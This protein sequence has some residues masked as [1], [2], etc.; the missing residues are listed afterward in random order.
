M[1]LKI[2]CSMQY[3]ST[4]KGVCGQIDKSAVCSNT[5]LFKNA[6]KGIK[7]FKKALKD[8]QN[9]LKSMVWCSFMW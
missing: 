6:L 9:A 3:C 8:L 7:D 5:A 4:R 2:L 1:V